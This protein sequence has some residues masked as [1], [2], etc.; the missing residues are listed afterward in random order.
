MGKLN[1]L[2]ALVRNYLKHYLPQEKKYS[3]HTVRA[4]Q[5]SL[6]LLFDFVKVKNGVTLEKVTFDMIDRDTLIEFLDYLEVERHCS[7]ITRNHRL[8]SIRAF[9]AYAA[10]R[11]LT[12]VAYW[13]E[14]STVCAAKV[15]EK[16]VEHMSEAAVNAVI[17]QADTSTQ[18]G[19]RD[20]FLMLLLYRTGARIQELLDI[21][22]RDIQFGKAPV[23]TLHGKGSKVRSVPLREN[24]VEHLRGYIKTFHSDEGTYSDQYLFYVVR[25]GA[26]KRMT[27]DN[28]RDFIR[29]YGV[30]ARLKCAEVP[31]TVHPHIFRHSCAMS[32]YRSGIPLSLISQ[33]LGHSCLETTII[34]ARADTEI[35]RNAI[36]N[37]IPKETPLGKHI[38]SERYKI[39]DENML[40]QLCGL[41]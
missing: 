2:F 5:K 36:E 31:E 22:I 24:T 16:L 38:N 40:R 34:Y 39:D 11:N 37:A 19:L 3:P 10:E 28:A 18:K 9:Y 14:I 4:Y 8:N 25:G 13:E 21:R 6:D 33:W 12:I 26:K 32:L 1:T 27:E 30:L 29:K 23:V 41:V 7:V 15:E 17:A 35:K 20:M